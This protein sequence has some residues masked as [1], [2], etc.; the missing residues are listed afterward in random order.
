MIVRRTDPSADQNSSALRQFQCTRILKLCNT[1]SQP[2]L[3]HQRFLRRALRIMCMMIMAVSECDAK[4]V[5]QFGNDSY[6][7][8]GLP[9]SHETAPQLNNVGYLELAK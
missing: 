5:L 8:N 6:H 9:R 3:R 1:I 2:Q 7:G 4:S